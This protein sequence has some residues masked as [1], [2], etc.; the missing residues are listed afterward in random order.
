MVRCWYGHQV[1]EGQMVN[2]EECES[3]QHV[4]CYYIGSRMPQVHCCEDCGSLYEE[5]IDANREAKQQNR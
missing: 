3:W 1:A 4:E 5:K 2:C